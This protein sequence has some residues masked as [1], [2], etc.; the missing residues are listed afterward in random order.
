MFHPSSHISRGPQ[1]M[2]THTIVSTAPSTS[3]TA[4]P[5]HLNATTKSSVPPR[6]NMNKQTICAKHLKGLTGI[7]WKKFKLALCS[8]KPPGKAE[9]IKMGNLN[10][11]SVE[12]V[13][14]SIFRCFTKR[15]GPGTIIRILAALSENEIRISIDRDIRKASKAIKDMQVHSSMGSKGATPNDNSVSSSGIPAKEM[16]KRDGDVP[17]QLHNTGQN[18]N[19][20]TRP[21]QNQT[22]QGI[23][24]II[25]ES[26]NKKEGPRPAQK[27]PKPGLSQSEKAQLSSP[28][29]ELKNR[30]V[31]CLKALTKGKIEHFETVLC[32]T[33]S[34]IKGGDIQME[35]IK[36]KSA[37]D[38]AEL[39][40]CRRTIRHAQATFKNVLVEMRENQLKMEFMKKSRKASTDMKDMLPHSMGPTGATPNDNSVSSSGIPAKKMI[41]RDGDVPG[42]LH[43]TGPNVNT[44]TRLI[45]KI[46][47]QASTDMKDML[48]HSMGPTGATPNDNSVSSSGIPAKKMIRRDGDVPGKLHNTG[49][50]VNTNTRLIQ[51]QPSQAST[52]MKDMLPHSMGPT[53]ATPND[54]SVS[55]SGIPAKKMIRQD[56]DVPGKLHNTGP[57][58]NTKTR[59]IQKQPSQEPQPQVNPEQFQ[60]SNLEYLLPIYPPMNLQS[61]QSL[62]NISM[63]KKISIIL[64]KHLKK[65]GEDGIKQ[66]KDFLCFNEPPIKKDK[67][68]TSEVKDKPVEY[69]VDLIIHRHTVE[70]VEK[71]IKN[72]LVFMKENNIQMLIEED[73]RQLHQQQ[74]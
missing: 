30:M 53:G 33:K 65:L 52:D 71:T 73:F 69:M 67:I 22:S 50:N 9:G 15:R 35:E 43:N 26:V 5:L 4:S 57:N 32:A 66:F 21:I 61:K 11:K 17:K 6:L 64:T 59:L 38:V 42:K 58:V 49:P 62:P 45:Q 3:V 70:Y 28:K 36:D 72:I 60:T 29:E 23:S 2:A 40:I 27:Q 19:K 25:Q 46:K 20:Q 56:G 34:R 48:P 16:I 13:V 12:Y 37:E 24:R 10:N 51:K 63:K 39:I 55:S 47:S 44:K 18:V 41:R 54:N 7:R 31:K 74:N 1:L 8:T 68:L 14:E